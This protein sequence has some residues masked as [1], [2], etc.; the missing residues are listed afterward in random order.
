[1]F[2]LKKEKPPSSVNSFFVSLSVLTLMETLSIGESK[3]SVLSV[4]ILFKTSKPLN[5]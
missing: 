3:E 2:Y 4:A 5:N 1:M